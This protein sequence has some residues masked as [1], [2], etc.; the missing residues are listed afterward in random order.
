MDA[1][2]IIESL[3]M[4]PHPEGGWYKETYRAPA[5]AEGGRGPVTAIYFLLDAGQRSH[6]HK[7]DA[8]ELWL[9]HAGGPLRLDLSPDGVAVQNRTLGPDL[10]AGERPQAVVPAGVWQAAGSLGAW[11]LVSCVVAPAFTFEGFE[12]AP[13]AWEPGVGEI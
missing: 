7:V 13:P 1:A 8:A 3:G 11:T 9:W 5:A 2:R 6:W 4:A 10:L 12:L